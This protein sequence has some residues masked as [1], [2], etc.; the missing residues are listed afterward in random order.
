MV[1]RRAARPPLRRARATKGP[2]LHFTT[3]AGAKLARQYINVIGLR[4]CH[5]GPPSNR[6]VVVCYA[7]ALSLHAAAA[8]GVILFVAVISAKQSAPSS[9]DSK[10]RHTDIVV[11]IV[12]LIPP[13]HADLSRP[14][15]ADIFA[16]L[17]TPMDRV[18]E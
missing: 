3:G 18:G 8:V 14:P 10:R 9:T 12:P 7:A 17:F 6:A 16:N 15:T 11:Q 4:R 5:T 1:S 13:S 2:A